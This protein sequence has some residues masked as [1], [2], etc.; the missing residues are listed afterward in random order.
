MTSQPTNNRGSVGGGLSALGV[1]DSQD[2]ISDEEESDSI[3]QTKKKAV[4]KKKRVKS[5]GSFANVK[6]LLN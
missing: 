1:I 2:V 6:N 4:K 5:K 3:K